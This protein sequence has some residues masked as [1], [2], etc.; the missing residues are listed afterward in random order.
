[1]K[2]TILIGFAFLM[3]SAV[4]AQEIDQKRMDRDLEVSKNILQTLF[5]EGNDGLFWGSRIEAS[6]LEGY[7]VIFTVPESFSYVSVTTDRIGRSNS[8]RSTVTT[9]E[10]VVVGSNNEAITLAEINSDSLQKVN[11]EQMKKHIMVFFAD[12]ASLIGQ[13]R[14]DDRIKIQNKDRHTEGFY[15]VYG[16]NVSNI[17][18]PTGFYSEVQ[19]QDIQA[20]KSGKI[21]RQAFEGKVVFEKAKPREKI[22]DLELFASI[23]RRLYSADLSETFFTES[24]PRYEKMD[25]YGVIFYM[26]TFSSYSNDQL[27]QMPVLGRSDVTSDERIKTI[28]ELYPKFESD[29][30]RQLI[31]YGRTISSLGADETLSMNITLTRCKDCDIPKSIVVSV[32][33]RVLQDVNQGKTRID[34]AVSSVKVKKNM[35]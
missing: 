2:R 10:P 6:Y 12:Y 3:I 7:G 8:R 31:E 24:T 27:Y 29:I 4:S 20:Y 23:I 32:P 25:N 26:K 28:Q 14:P 33:V 15:M 30:K 35:N 16:S 9:T 18:S 5:R 11:M 21:S 17:Q 34:Q 1:M 19:V 13:L 22:Q